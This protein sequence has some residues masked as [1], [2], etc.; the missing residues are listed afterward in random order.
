M[1]ANG[2]RPL[3]MNSNPR[4]G[5]TWM[6]CSTR[7]LAP[8]SRLVLVSGGVLGGLWRYVSSSLHLS[9]KIE[10]LTLSNTPGPRDE[11]LPLPYYWQ[12][13]LRTRSPQSRQLRGQRECHT[14]GET[15]SLILVAVGR[16]C[17]L[18]IPSPPSVISRSRLGRMQI[19]ERLCSG[20]DSVSVVVLPDRTVVFDIVL[21]R[22]HGRGVS[23]QFRSATSIHSFPPR[24]LGHYLTW[25][26]PI[27]SCRI[28]PP[29][30]NCT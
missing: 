24:P 12:L 2:T 25:K 7:R 27:E 19:S 20:D 30:P 9:C 29:V 16:S 5:S 26:G 23:Y 3:L 14:K 22:H 21:L 1:R 15:F 4:G 11:A 8:P 10:P 28:H 6:D 17:F 18:R 13:L